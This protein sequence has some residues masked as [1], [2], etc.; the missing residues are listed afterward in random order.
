MTASEIYSI[1]GWYTY[2]NRRE[3]IPQA[4]IF[5]LNDLDG[6]I[7]HG[8]IHDARWGTADI[9]EGFLD[10]RTFDFAKQYGDGS[11]NVRY[12]MAPHLG[13]WRGNWK[14]EKHIGR[15]ELWV[16]RI[17]IGAKDFSFDKAS[18]DAL[19]PRRMG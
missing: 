19:R 10:D 6:R 14:A 15:A 8:F 3:R 9:S 12:E 7:E 4:G 18:A 16:A 17:A 2:A 11:D 5:Q 1:Y 13:H